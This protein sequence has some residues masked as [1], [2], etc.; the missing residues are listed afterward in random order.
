M[1]VLGLARAAGVSPNT[2]TNAE[3]G[4]TMLTDASAKKL[5]R[6]LGVEPE[7]IAERPG[8]YRPTDEDLP[9]RRL[10]HQLGLSGREAA[11]RI[12]V[13]RMA[14]MRAETGGRVYPRNA[15]R[16]ASFYGISADAFVG[17]RQRL[18]HVTHT[19]GEDAA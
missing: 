7:A 3:R 18:S 12:G 5:A 13:S 17:R 16:I 1:T 4:R 6:A 8:Q 10:R 9:L 14:L 11:E 2:I 19:D 15:E